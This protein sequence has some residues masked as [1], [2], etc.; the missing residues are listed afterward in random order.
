M[1]ESVTRSRILQLAWPIVLANS[2]VPLLGLVDTAVIGNTGSTAELGAVGL[3]S[4]IF[5]FV[6]WGFGFLRMGTTGFTAQASGR[7]DTAEVRAALA[8][9]LLLAGTL[10]VLL[11][12]L[13]VP[14]RWSALGLLGASPEVESLTGDYFDLRIWAAP[15][16]LGMF[17]V[18]GSLIGL[19]R[20]RHVLATQFFLNGLNMALDV[21]FAGV[22]GLGIRGIAL[23]T[24]L[25]EWIAFAFGI[26]LLVQVL[27]RER[28]DEEA[29]WPVDRIRDTGQARAVL[30]ANADIM[31]RTLFLLFGF[32]WFTNQGAVF[33]NEILAANHVLLQLVSLSAYLLDGYAHATEVLVGRAVGAGDPDGFD[34]VV[35]LSSQMSAVTAAG[36]GL[37]L[38]VVGPALVDRLTDLAAVRRVALDYL[39][40]AAG[41]VTLSFAAFQLDG[42]FI[43]ATATRAMRNASILSLLG[44]LGASLPLAGRFGN[45]GL[46]IAFLV[47]VILRALALRIRYGTARNR[48]LRAST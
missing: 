43:G 27:R 21:L 45:T 22:L 38:L 16:S 17:S 47:F 19:G 8:R 20:T 36:L 7:G 12:I 25:A 30:T 39:P 2:A 46:W 31:V 32:G 44:F 23:G 28:R 42:V 29:W 33:G 6:F 37:A 4:L 3:G 5:S 1:T 24:M 10:G 9:A 13:Q 34:H 48:A 35:R 15:A 18:T 41:Y 26:V 11:L 14:I 40:F